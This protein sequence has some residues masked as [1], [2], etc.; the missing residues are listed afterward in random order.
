MAATV[1]TRANGG[2]CKD[3]MS[4]T[5]RLRRDARWQDGQPLTARDVAFTFSAI[6]NAHNNVIYRSGYDRVAR[7]EALNQT[8]VRVRLRNRTQ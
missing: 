2:I 1:P 8:T 6:M 7:V 5:Y 4:I 3:G